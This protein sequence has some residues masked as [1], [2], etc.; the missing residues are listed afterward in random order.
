MQFITI[1]VL[2]TLA[3]VAAFAPSARMASSSA[4]KMSFEV[5]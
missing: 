4:L 3:S 1:V 2:A 5:S